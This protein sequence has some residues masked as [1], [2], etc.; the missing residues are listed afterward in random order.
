VEYFALGDSYSSGEG[1]PPYDP[2]TDT[3]GLSNLCH[4]STTGAYAT[5]FAQSSGAYLG[6]RLTPS[7]SPSHF[8]ACSGARIEHVTGG[9]TWNSEAGQLTRVTSDADLITVT[10]GG[11]DVRAVN[12]SGDSVVGFDRILEG[13]ILARNPCSREYADLKDTIPDLSAELEAAYAQI[14]DQ[15]P[16]ARVIVLTY[17]QIFPRSDDLRRSVAGSGFRRRPPPQPMCALISGPELD[18]I[19]DRTHQLNQVIVSAAAAAGVESLDVESAFTNHLLCSRDPW[20]NNL[21]LPK[22]HIFHPNRAGH[23]RLAELLDARV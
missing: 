2:I 9:V 14:R 5:V 6:S 8:L 22:A 23:A 10:M 12:D 18:W 20:A 4:R 11:N 16:G 15:V 7:M 3:P 13:C 1:V 19:R 17:P 21:T